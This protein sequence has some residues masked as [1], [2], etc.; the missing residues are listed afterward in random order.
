MTAPT[1]P[2]IDL[3]CTLLQ[4]RSITP[5]DAGCQALLSSRLAALGFR[6]EAMPFA[7]VSNLWARRGKG[8]PLLCFAG[9]TDVV[10]P[11]ELAE[12]ATDPFQPVIRDGVLYARGSADMKGGLAAMTVALEGFVADNPDHRGSLAV[13]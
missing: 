6:C 10:P 12:W 7:D 1:P 8:S 4:R 9:H 5:D 3:L 2:E 13:L 11:G